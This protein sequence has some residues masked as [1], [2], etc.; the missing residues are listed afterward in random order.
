MLEGTVESNITLCKYHRTTTKPTSTIL[1]SINCQYYYNGFLHS[2]PSPKTPQQ[3]W[4]STKSFYVQALLLSCHYSLASSNI[5][6]FFLIPLTLLFRGHEFLN[7]HSFKGRTRY[8]SKLT[9]F[10]IWRPMASNIPK[11]TMTQQRKKKTKNIVMIMKKQILSVLLMM[12]C[13]RLEFVFDGNRRQRIPSSY[14]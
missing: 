6:F 5:I 14:C 12:I 9:F 4:I 7:F 10:Y 3:Q 8:C 1:K 2:D 11:A 13:F